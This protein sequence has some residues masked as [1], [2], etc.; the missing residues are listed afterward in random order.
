MALINVLM[1]IIIIYGIRAVREIGVIRGSDKGGCDW[2]V[3]IRHEKMYTMLALPSPGFISAPLC[4][5]TF[6]QIY[7]FLDRRS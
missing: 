4:P 2:F 7:D 1:S 3:Y 6:F 5:C